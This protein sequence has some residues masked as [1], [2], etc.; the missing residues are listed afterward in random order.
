M[1]T[2]WTT[3]SSERSDVNDQELGAL[4]KQ[5]STAHENLQV[6]SSQ[7]S[8][9]RVDLQTIENNYANHRRAVDELQRR[10][11]AGAEQFSAEHKP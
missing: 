8:K 9:A 11:I 3:S 4:A 1:A 10:F 6:L 5:L 2:G 7:L